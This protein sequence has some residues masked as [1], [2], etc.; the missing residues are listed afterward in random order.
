MRRSDIALLSIIPD[1]A[2]YIFTLHDCSREGLAYYGGRKFDRLRDLGAPSR[3]CALSRYGV[4]A[5]AR[6]TSHG[7]VLVFSPKDDRSS[8]LLASTI[9]VDDVSIISPLMVRCQTSPSMWTL[10]GD[11]PVIP[12]VAFIR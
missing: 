7:I 9:L 5:R 4:K 6:P 12:G 2:D 11:K 1:G 8:P 10:G 3:A